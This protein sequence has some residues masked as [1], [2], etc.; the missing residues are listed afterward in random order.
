M[1]VEAVVLHSLFCASLDLRGKVATSI[2]ALDLLKG[3][4]LHQESLSEELPAPTE[5]ARAA[6]VRQT[7][8]LTLASTL[9]VV[10]VSTS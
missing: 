3:R 10:A 2:L 5:V 9:A 7:N 8:Q 1:Y 4:S 6:T